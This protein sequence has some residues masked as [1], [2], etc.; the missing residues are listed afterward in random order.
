MKFDSQT[1][2]SLVVPGR[3]NSTQVESFNYVDWVVHAG[4]SLITG[5]KLSCPFNWHVCKRI[6]MTYIQTF[7]KEARDYEASIVES[8]HV[9]ND[10][11]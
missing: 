5:T 8:T 9:N 7:C 1:A 3:H 2:V 11:D 6:I 10:G 4:D